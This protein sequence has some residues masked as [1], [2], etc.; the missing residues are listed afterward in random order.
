MNAAPNP[1]SA[2]RLSSARLIAFSIAGLSIG[3]VPTSLTLFIPAFYSQHFGL[4]LTL[5]GYVF[6]LSRLWNAF[7]DPVVGV[8]SDRTHTRFGQRKPWIA[9]GGLLLLVATY[10]V[11]VPIGQ[12]NGYSLALWLFAVYLGLSMLS[13][14]LYAWAGSLSDQYHERTRIQT[15]LQVMTALGPALILMIPLL[16]DRLGDQ[17]QAAKVASMGWFVVASL[18]IGLPI[19]IFRFH[20]RAAPAL[21]SRLSF[22]AAIRL[23]ATDR[24]VLRVI[25]SDFFVSLGQ[26]FRGSLFVFFISA[27]LGLP[28]WAI[29]TLPLVQ[30]IFGVFASPIWMQ[31]AYRLGKHRT[32]VAGEV[33]QIAINLAILALPRGALWGMMALVVAQGLSQGSGN[34]MLKA[35]VSDVADKERLSTG[36]EH[37]GLLFSIFNVTQNAAM[38][39]ATGLALQLVQLFGFLPTSGSG[40]SAAA[41][42]GLRYVF[43]FGPAI[44]HGL[45]A[46]LMWRFPLDEK[47]HAEIIRELK[48]SGAASPEPPAEAD[49]APA[50]ALSP[51][52]TRSTA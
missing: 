29:F 13:T 11:F 2:G 44:G 48:A 4:P 38:A 6:L 36:K 34:L 43:A 49:A 14:P 41:L 23:L 16:L 19:L 33:T 52:P 28:S 7:S 50:A 18:A 31:V 39:L 37:A 32:V 40:N 47:R 3:S 46:L 17:D 24:V 15:H 8:L 12:P 51:E 20:E 9:V 42:D 45:S 10:A 35:I 22:G 30:Y 27:Y 1:S 25:G 26:G 21:A 5:V